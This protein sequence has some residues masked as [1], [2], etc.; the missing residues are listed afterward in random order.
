AGA[1][2]SAPTLTIAARRDGRSTVIRVGDNGPGVP[3]KAREHLFEAF[4]GT[5]RRGGVGLGLAITAELVALHG[6]HIV[7]EEEGPGATF[8][9]HLPDRT[10]GNGA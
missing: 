7:L 2:P 5:S 3:A 8:R 4:Q 6:G 1:G 10:N 9:I